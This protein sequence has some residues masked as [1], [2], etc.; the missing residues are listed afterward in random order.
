MPQACAA[1]FSIVSHLVSLACGERAVELS[2][3]K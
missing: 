2:L 3:V 1:K